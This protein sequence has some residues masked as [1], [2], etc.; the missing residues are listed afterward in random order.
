MVFL[1][2]A[3]NRLDIQQQQH[4]EEPQRVGACADGL[5]HGLISATRASVV[6]ALG[7]A[8]TGLLMSTSQVALL[9]WLFLPLPQE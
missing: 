9:I 1:V 3:A 7:E 2:S 5:L 8:M 4:V 6:P